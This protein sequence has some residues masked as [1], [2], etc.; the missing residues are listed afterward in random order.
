VDTISIVRVT[1]RVLSI[2]RMRRH[3][4]RVFAITS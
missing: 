1:W 2:E 4:A 3:S